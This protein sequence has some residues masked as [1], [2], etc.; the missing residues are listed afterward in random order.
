[1]I[2]YKAL[3][4]ALTVAA[5]TATGGIASA[6]NAQFPAEF[7]AMIEKIHSNQAEQRSRIMD[8]IRTTNT[9]AR[10]SPAEFE[11]MLESIRVM[12]MKNRSKVM[13]IVNNTRPE[14]KV[15]VIT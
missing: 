1:M 12:Q 4:M 11:K 3:A 10:K 9:S 2:K 13:E 6:S 8:E 14:I 7:K 15:V 5:A